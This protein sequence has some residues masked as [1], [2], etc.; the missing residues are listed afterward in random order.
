M[1]GRVLQ[2]GPSLPYAYRPSTGYD[3]EAFATDGS[4]GIILT[5]VPVVTSS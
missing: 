4:Q 5:D 2:N 1:R 3:P